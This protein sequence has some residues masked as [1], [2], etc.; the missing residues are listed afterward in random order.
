MRLYKCQSLQNLHK[1]I[2]FVSSRKRCLSF[3]HSCFSCQNFCL[4][5]L[6]DRF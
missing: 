5:S 6:Y 2:V 4:T 1:I 3:L